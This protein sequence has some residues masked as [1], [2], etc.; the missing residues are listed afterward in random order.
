MWCEI[1]FNINSGLKQYIKICFRNKLGL[2]ILN[3]VDNFMSK[4]NFDYTLYTFNNYLNIKKYEKQW[5]WNKKAILLII[6]M[7]KIDK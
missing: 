1:I 5:L 7:N 3:I 2:H 4:L 6:L